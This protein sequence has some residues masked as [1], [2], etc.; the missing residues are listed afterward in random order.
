MYSGRPCAQRSRL[1]NRLRPVVATEA[2]SFAGYLKVNKPDA[3]LPSFTNT[4]TGE[5]FMRSLRSLDRGLPSGYDRQP[6]T[7]QDLSKP[8]YLR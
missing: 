8:S 1:G 7:S 3:R 2:D 4:E 5:I 6:V